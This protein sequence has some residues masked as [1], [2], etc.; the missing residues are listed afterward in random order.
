MYR[1]NKEH[2]KVYDWEFLDIGCPMFDI[3]DLLLSISPRYINRKIIDKLIEAYVEHY[4][5][6]AG[7]TLSLE[8]YFDLLYYSALKYAATRMN[9]YLLCYK[10]KKLKYIER[11]YFNLR[12]ILKLYVPNQ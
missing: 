12:Q 4:S 2:L 3:V 6:L 9:M 1:E 10:R 11:M 5:K 8:H 7:V